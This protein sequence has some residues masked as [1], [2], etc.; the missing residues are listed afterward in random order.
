GRVRPRVRGRDRPRARRPG[1]VR[2]LQPR[3]HRDRAAR[4]PRGR[5][6]RAQAPGQSRWPGTTAGEFGDLAGLADL[7]VAA[8]FRPAWIETAT[9]AE[10]E[11]FESGYQC[12]EEE[13]L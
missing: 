7:A 3:A 9:L 5:A 11:E 8:G 12:D 2:R 1:A 6:G 13:W 10:W 4:A